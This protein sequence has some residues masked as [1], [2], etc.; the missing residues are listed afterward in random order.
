MPRT[1]HS[2]ARLGVL[3]ASLLIVS[4]CGGAEPAALEPMEP[5]VPAD[6]CST[7]PEA[8]RDGLVSNSNSDPH[9]NANAHTDPAGGAA[10]SPAAAYGACPR[11]GGVAR[12][13]RPRRCGQRHSNAD[14]AARVAGGACGPR[15][16]P[17]NSRGQREG[18]KHIPRKRGAQGAGRSGLSTKTGAILSLSR[19]VRHESPGRLRAGRAVSISAAA[20]RLLL[21]LLIGTVGLSVP[22]AAR[23]LPDAAHADFAGEVASRDARE[24]AD[25]VVASRDNHALP[26]IIIDKVAAKVFVFDAKGE[27]R[28][29]SPALLGAGRGDES[30]PGIGQRKLATI[31][32][33]ERTTTAGRFE[34]AL[35]NDFDQDILWVDYDTSLSLHRVIVGNP[36]DRRHARLAS[37]TPLDNRISYGCINVPARFYDSI[38]VPAFKGTVGIVYILPETKPL[39]AVFTMRGAP[40]ARVTAT[41][42]R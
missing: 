11:G 22:G 29:A 23:A 5:E 37:P 33:A 9:A 25:W 13:S 8:A 7:V 40:A 27:I 6:L 36:K 14:H 39:E 18:R 15:A 41:P 31:R 4:G 32:P 10:C 34:A 1:A 42:S 19:F 2:R 35:G 17:D 3:T 20:R 28:G 24:V 38:V 30:V 12:W 26:F 16:A 21:G